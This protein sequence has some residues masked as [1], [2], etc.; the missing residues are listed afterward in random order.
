MLDR[1]TLHSIY[2]AEND[3]KRPSR[4]WNTEMGRLLVEI[5]ILIQAR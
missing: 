4:Q 1:T 5:Q 2:D 3:K